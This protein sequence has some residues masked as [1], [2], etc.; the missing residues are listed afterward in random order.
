M[1]LKYKELKLPEFDLSLALCGQTDPEMFFPD[2]SNGYYAAAAKA[3]CKQCPVQKECLAWALENDEE[4]GVWGGLTAIERKNL[5]GKR[6]SYRWKHLP[7]LP[8]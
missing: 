1:A 2:N 8:E 6:L 7:V 3:I 4:F 5:K